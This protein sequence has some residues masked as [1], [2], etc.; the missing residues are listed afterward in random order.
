MTWVLA[1]CHLQF[2]RLVIHILYLVKSMAELDSELIGPEVC[3]VTILFLLNLLIYLIAI[4]T[5]MLFL[6]E[7]ATSCGI[8]HK[9]CLI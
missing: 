6:N 8:F 4:R 3:Y 1:I 2:I 7:F 9:N 5:F